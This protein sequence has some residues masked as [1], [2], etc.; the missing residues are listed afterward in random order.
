MTHTVQELLDNPERIANLRLD[1][2]HCIRC[3]V[4]LSGTLTE[5]HF[6]PRGDLCDGKYLAYLQL[7]KSPASTR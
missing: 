3:G 6:S 7:G 1:P 4:P 5:R 2:E